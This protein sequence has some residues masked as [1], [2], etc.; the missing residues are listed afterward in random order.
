[1]SHMRFR[2][3]NHNKIWAGK[4]LT[5]S[6]QSCNLLGCKTQPP[7]FEAYQWMPVSLDK[8]KVSN[9]NLREMVLAG[10]Y[11]NS[12]S[13]LDSSKYSG[14]NAIY[15][16]SQ[17]VRYISELPN[18]NNLCI[19]FYQSLEKIGT[20]GLGF[21]KIYHD[22]LIQ[23]NELLKSNLEDALLLILQ[24]EKQYKSLSKLFFLAGK[25]KEKSYLA[26][27]REVLLTIWDIEKQMWQAIYQFTL[28][29]KGI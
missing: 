29:E 8:E 26:D 10:L 17:E 18:W 14:V 2:I 5:F 21:R 4:V 19:Q 15:T 16:L 28:K 25:R 23:A 22:F 27:L 24:L 3:I 12:Q 11:N 20:G 7:L 6:L 1:A 9:I 13:M